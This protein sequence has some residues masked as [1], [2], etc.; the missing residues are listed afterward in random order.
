[1]EVKM[2]RMRDADTRA[3]TFEPEG[4]HVTTMLIN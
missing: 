3:C 2:G 4:E 1:M